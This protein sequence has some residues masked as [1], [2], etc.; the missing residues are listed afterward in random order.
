[1]MNAPCVHIDWSTDGLQF[2]LRNNNIIVIVDT[3]RFS[4]AV[5][6]AIAHGFT[7]YPVADMQ[8]GRELAASVGAAMAGKPGKAEYSLSPRSFIVQNSPGRTVVLYSPNGATCASRIQSTDIA[9]IGCF[10]NAR[11]VAQHVRACVEATGRNVTVLACGEQRAFASGERIIYSKEDSQR[12][13]AVE[14]YLASGAII[15]YLD[16]NKTAEATVCARAFHTTRDQLLELLLNSFSGRYLKDKGLAADV[17]H[18]AQIDAYDDVPVILH[19]RIE[20]D[21]AQPVA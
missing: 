19:G 3:L 11:A 15:S 5:V 18:A 4:S 7:I 1:M 20:K 21:A 8:K 17:E 16:L 9:Y 10:L 14:D 12:V 6:T 13:F 2:A